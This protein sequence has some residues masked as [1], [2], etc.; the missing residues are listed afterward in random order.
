MWGRITQSPEAN[1]APTLRRFYSF[2][3]LSFFL[4]KKYAIL[5][6]F[7]WSK[8]LLKNAMAE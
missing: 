6:I 4:S 3:F 5:G 8:F 7:C 2:F 1:G